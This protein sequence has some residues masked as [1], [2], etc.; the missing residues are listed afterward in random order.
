MCYVSGKDT[1]PEFFFFFFR[2]DVNQNN[3]K[4]PE[5]CDI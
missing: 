3:V 1:S 4:V 2:V 5:P